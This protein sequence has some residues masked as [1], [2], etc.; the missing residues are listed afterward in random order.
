M[1]FRVA[2]HTND[3]Q[4]LVDFYSLIPGMEI[5]G[6]FKNHSGYDGVFLG[7]KNSDWHLEFT[8]STDLPK[9]HTDEDDQLVFYVETEKQFDSIAEKFRQNNIAETESKNPYWT[10]NGKTYTDPDGFRIVI[11]KK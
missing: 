2:R 1:K 6:E 4:R 3:L 11:T 8:V 7:I 9:H 5:I 10:L